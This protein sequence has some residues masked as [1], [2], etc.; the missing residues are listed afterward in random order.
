MADNVIANPG[1]GGA[2]FATDEVAGVH[3]PVGKLAYG[4]ADSATM[5]SMSNPLP[6][7]D[8]G[9]SLTVDMTSLPALATGTNTIGS[10]GLAPRTSGGL[11]ISRV[12]SAATTNATSVKASAGQVFGWFASNVNAAARYL[13]LYNKASAPTV[14]SDTPVMTILIPGNTAGAGT[15]IEY[16]NGIAFATGIALAL[17]TGVADADTGAVAANELVVNLLYA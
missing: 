13:K 2:T 5:V 17:T 10:V 9:G 3:Y 15:N 6:V 12:I 1:A 4:A 7:A 8:G 14:G 11:S 16:T